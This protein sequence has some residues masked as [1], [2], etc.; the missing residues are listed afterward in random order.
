MQDVPKI[1]VKRLQSAAA[2]S[3]PDA[4]LLTA[5]A[6]RS[7]SGRER[8]SVLQHLARCGDCREVVA[9]A[10]PAS[11]A[12]EIAKS[13]RAARHWFNVPVLRWGV[14]AAGM[15]FVISVG[16]L[17][18]RQRHQE[19]ISVGL[20][21]RNQLADTQNSPAAPASQPLRMP[22][23]AAE[24]TESRTKSVARG[25]AGA[26]KKTLSANGAFPRSQLMYGTGSGSGVAG[27]SSGAA[28]GGP[29]S[30]RDFAS[31]LA[32]PSPAAAPTAKQNAVPPTTNK[33]AEVSGASQ[34][35]E[36]Q[37]A[38]PVTTQTAQ[39]QVKDELL[40]ND[41][42]GRVG[43]AKPALDQV[44][45]TVV[46]APP[47]LRS[48]T[49]LKGETTPRWT[50]SAGG[51]LQ[52]SLDG[53][54]TWVDVNFAVDTMSPNLWRGSTAGSTAE[55]QAQVQTEKKRAPK[56]TAKSMPQAG[57]SVA[58]TPTIFRAL[59]VSSNAAEVWAGGSGG[60]LYHT[61]DGGNLWVRVLPSADGVALT[62]DV[63]SIQFP[64]V[65]N[66]SVTT[67]NAEVWVTN[68][69]GQTWRKQQ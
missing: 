20:M 8:E 34:M 10:L 32:P 36:M 69:D 29:V 1:V 13:G 59:S 11:D 31:A 4:D 35:V 58:S 30:R 68:D 17:Q 63:I 57:K 48:G 38:A 67:S 54:K 52:R 66:G 21:A 15:A 50:I 27:G 3:H 6:E 64:D 5:F 41:E 23:A 7:L 44:S 51:V 26:D 40:Q 60:T 39:N 49:N 18:Y 56:V 62:G 46:L 19:K 25:A 45:P 2:E 61:L 53:G 9:L 16:V 55:V 65:S 43:K 28:M 24:P 42:A 47:E 22:V 33:T 37:S 14:L 12:A